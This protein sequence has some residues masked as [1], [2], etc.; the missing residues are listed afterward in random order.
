MADENT[1]LSYSITYH[2]HISLYYDNPNIM[3]TVTF[4]EEQH[5]VVVDCG[6]PAEEILNKFKEVYFG[7]DG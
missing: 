6:K 2:S 1:F 5:E 3:L 7:V 4:E